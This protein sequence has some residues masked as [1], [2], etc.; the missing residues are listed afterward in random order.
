MEEIVSCPLCHMAVRPTDFFCFNCGKNL[1]TAPLSTSATDQLV[2]YAKSIFLL[3]MGFVW[4]MRYLRQP[5][6]KSKIV[7]I[8][9]M[10]I[11]VAVILWLVGY[12]V[13]AIN[14]VN[15]QMGTQFQGLEGF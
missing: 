13:G 15:T 2:L 12:M 4:G 9:A 8:I 10:A 3:P 1:H 7:G 6:Q 5:D 14:S 11:T